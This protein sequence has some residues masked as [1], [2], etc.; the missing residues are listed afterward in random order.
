MV[1]ELH[2]STLIFS[3]NP[4]PTTHAQDKHRDGFEIHATQCPN[5]VN[6]AEA[7]AAVEVCISLFSFWW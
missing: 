3:L 4:H 1:W 7:V 6:I 5:E 2:A